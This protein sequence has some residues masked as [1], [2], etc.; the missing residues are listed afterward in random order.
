MGGDSDVFRLVGRELITSVKSD[1][2][3]GDFERS[4]FVAPLKIVIS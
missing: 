4:R 1:Q 3:S 2:F